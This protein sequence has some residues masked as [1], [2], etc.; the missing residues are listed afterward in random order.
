[1]K[2]L[3]GAR[4]ESVRIALGATV[5]VFLTIGLVISNKYIVAV[6]GFDYIVFLSCLHVVFT[7][8]GCSIACYFHLFET[9]DFPPKI[10]L[11]VAFVSR[12]LLVGVHTDKLIV[13]SLMGAKCPHGRLH[14]LEW[15]S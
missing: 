11:S 13:V 8:V 14:Q 9:R 4:R 3:A 10:K 15:C 7:Y 1:M 2:E 6:D 5:N 12:R